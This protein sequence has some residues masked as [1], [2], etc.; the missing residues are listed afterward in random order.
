MGADGHIPAIIPAPR[1][2]Q[3]P[4]RVVILSMDGHLAHAV[5]SAAQTLRQS[6]PGLTV[7][8]HVAADCE[9]DGAKLQHARDDIERANIIVAGMLFLE[10]QI[11]PLIEAL[12]ARAPHCD[13]IVGCLSAPEIVKLTRLGKFDMGKPQSGAIALLKRLKGKSGHNHTNGAA[14]ARLLRRLP[15]ILKFIPGTAQDVR[16]YFLTMQYWLAGSEDNIRNMIAALVDRYSA[17]PREACKGKVHVDP[18]VI[19][20]EIGVYHPLIP[21]RISEAA[22][23]LPHDKRKPT[24]GLILMRSYILSGD[25]GHYDSVIAALEARGMNVVPAFASGLDARPAIHRFFARHDG[26]IAQAGAIGGAQIDLL[27][28]LTG[29]S[30]IGGPAYNDANAASDILTE[31]DVPYMAAHALEFQ[32][33]DEWATRKEGLSPVEATMMVAIPE[34]DGATNPTVF[35]GRVSGTSCNGCDRRCQFLSTSSAAGAPA[36]IAAMRGC[37]ERISQLASRVEKMVQLRHTPTADKRVAVVLF[38]FPPNSGAT[39]TA[40]YL[41]VFASLHN[42]LKTLAADGYTVD[43]PDSVDALRARVL[44]GNASQL[45]TDANVCGRVGT[46]DHVRREVR[47]ADIEAQ[48]GSAPGRHQTD[49]RDIHILG[50]QFGNILVAVQPAFGYEG[51]PMRLLFDQGF[52]P[53]HAFAAFYRYLRADFAADAVLHFGTHGALEFMPGKQSGLS[54]AC[55]PDYLIGETPNF[56]F[57]AANNPSEAALAKRRSAATT[58]SYLTPTVTRADLYKGLADLRALIDQYRTIAN[59]FTARH[60]QADGSVRTIAHGELL[61]MIIDAAAGL[62]LQHPALNPDDP[63]SS[64]AMIAHL[65]T[66]L[67]ELEQALIPSG[68]HIA[69]VPMNRDARFNVLSAIAMDRSGKSS[70]PD[71]LAAIVDGGEADPADPQI[72]DLVALNEALQQNDELAALARALAGR[73]IAPVAGGDVLKNTDI[74]PTGRNI[75]GFD[76]FR[77]PSAFATAEGEAQTRQ[78]LQRH[79]Q[80]GESL[81]EMVAIVLWGTDNLKSE[82]AQLAQA[83]ALMGARARFDAFGRLCGAELIPLEALARPRID[84][85]ATL[86]GIFRDLLP[87]QTRMLAEAAYLAAIAD[88]PVEQNFVRKHALR[89]ADHLGCDMQ[90]AA[91]RV[92]SNADGAYGA[93]VNQMIDAGCWEEEDELADAYEARKGYAFPPKGPPQAEGALLNLILADVD[94]AYQNLESVELGVTT[95]DHYFDT[96][97]GISRAVQRARG[98]PAPIYICDQTRSTGAVRTLNEQVALETRTRTLNPKW[99]ESM[100]AHGYEG[101]SQ[102]EAQVKNTMGW[103]ATTSDVAPWVYQAISDTFVLDPELRDRLAS[104]NPKSCA[105][106]AHRLIEASE[107]NYWSPDDATLEALRAAGDDLDDRIEGIHSSQGA[108]A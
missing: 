74:L 54:G 55:W 101:V 59:D 12:E 86:S 11:S 63:Q 2:D 62:E 105:R 30:L 24:I 67:D 72:R 84:V 51:D 76:P 33:I 91:L 82:G 38:N 65:R 41:D 90:R 31:L 18:P 40:A 52:A 69:G 8:F 27:L 3:V 49:G 58:I 87:M 39:G 68:L 43:V 37:A 71:A 80:T 21:G 96:L 14:Q 85:V 60:Q 78:I 103:S 4:V 22:G 45:G 28:S 34:L 16:A 95:I 36:S 104:L 64:S 26:K 25:T 53:T 23:D 20:P 83:M 10:S 89:Y 94:L 75:H 70:P 99:Y 61:S 57:Y 79:C 29:F 97:G 13:A 46:D 66:A 88:E 108:I 98:K 17:G 106:V 15:K 102:I 1:G 77:M 100:L 5:K 42:F 35:G 93:N 44:E 7:S 48:W 19:Y 92:F 47:L 73:F 32:T 9:K 6:V 56:Y 50:E 81:P 107:R